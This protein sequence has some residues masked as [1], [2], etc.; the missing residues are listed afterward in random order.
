VAFVTGVAAVFLLPLGGLVWGVFLSLV[1][2]GF[3][4]VATTLALFRREDHPNILMAAL[5]L[6]ALPIGLFFNLLAPGIWRELLRLM[7][8]G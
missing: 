1:A 8:S 7:T 2:V 5:L 6:C 3:S 4:L